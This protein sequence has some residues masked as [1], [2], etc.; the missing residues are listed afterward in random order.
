MRTMVPLAP[1][2]AAGATVDGS[3]ADR[4]HGATSEEQR[5]ETLVTDSGTARAVFDV[6]VA[7]ASEQGGG[8]NGQS[9]SGEAGSLRP[10]GGRPPSIASSPLLALGIKSFY[11]RSAIWD[12]K[13]WGR[14]VSSRK[15]LRRA[16]IEDP[17][18]GG[19]GG[20]HLFGSVVACKPHG[21]VCA[22]LQTIL[23]GAAQAH[24]NIA[25]YA[26]VRE[27]SR[28]QVS[29]YSE[30]YPGNGLR[31]VLRVLVPGA[32]DA[33]L[34]PTEYWAR[35]ARAAASM[36]SAAA[37][38]V[39][40]S[41]STEKEKKEESGGSVTVTA[42]DMAWVARGAPLTWDRVS[43]V[44][45]DVLF[46]LSGQH[47][48]MANGSSSGKWVHL[49]GDESALVSVAAHPHRR[50]LAPSF[51]VWFLYH[52]L[53]AIA[54]LNRCGIV[55]RCLRPEAFMFDACGELV[56][57]DWALYTATWNGVC[58]PFPIGDVAYLPPEV[59]EVEP[60][61]AKPVLRRVERMRTN[62]DGAV[63]GIASS[64][65]ISSS[66][67]GSGTSRR[68]VVDSHD[69]MLNSVDA[70]HPCTDVWS[71]GIVALQLL[72]LVDGEHN[73]SRYTI[74]KNCAFPIP[75]EKCEAPADIV[76]H[77]LDFCA[78]LI[79]GDPKDDESNV[80]GLPADGEFVSKEKATQWLI[81]SGGQHV[82]KSVEQWIQDV[83]KPY[84]ACVS[85]SASTG[86]GTQYI[87]RTLS[88]LVNVL[89]L[90]LEPDASRRPCASVLL[91]HPIFSSLC[92]Q[93]ADIER[94]GELEQQRPFMS[95]DS[96]HLRNRMGK[97]WYKNPRYFT[98]SF[99]WGSRRCLTTGLYGDGAVDV[100]EDSDDVCTCEACSGCGELVSPVVRRLLG[101]GDCSG[102]ESHRDFCGDCLYGF[103]FD[104]ICDITD[105]VDGTQHTPQVVADSKA[106]VN[107]QRKGA[108]MVPPWTYA[109]NSVFWELEVHRILAFARL[110]VVDV[111]PVMLY[112]T[113]LTDDRA[114]TEEIDPRRGQ[115]DQRIFSIPLSMGTYYGHDE[116]G[117]YRNGWGPT[118]AGP[119][120]S[121]RVHNSHS[122]GSLWEADGSDI[123]MRV[124][125]SLDRIMYR[126]C[127]MGIGPFLRPVTPV[128]VL[129][130]RQ[131]IFSA[132]E[133][134]LV[135][136]MLSEEKP[137]VFCSVRAISRGGLASPDS[138]LRRG[139]PFALALKLEEAEYEERGDVVEDWIL[140]GVEMVRV[141]GPASVEG[142]LWR[143]YAL[144]RLVFMAGSSVGARH[145]IRA[146]GRC[147]ACEIP[148]WLRGKVWATLLCPRGV[149]TRE[150][151]AEVVHRSLQTFDVATDSQMRVD[152][153]RCHQYLSLM[154]SLYG[155]EVVSVMVK[156]F[157]YSRTGCHMCPVE[158]EEPESDDT[159][160]LMGNHG[161]TSASAPN[162]PGARSGSGTP[163][164]IGRERTTTSSAG[165]WAGTFARARTHVYW[166][167][168]VSVATVFL[169]VF[170]SEPHIAYHCFSTFVNRVLANHFVDRSF[171]PLNERMW[172]FVH[173]LTYHD[174]EL[175]M[176][177]RDHDVTP[178][179]FGVPWF[180]TAFSHAFPAS[181]VVKI[182]DGIISWFGGDKEDEACLGLGDFDH[183]EKQQKK[184]VDVAQVRRGQMMR[185]AHTSGPVWYLLLFAVS[186][187]LQKRA[188]LLER[189]YNGILMYV[190]SVH[191]SVDTS[192]ER[193]VSMRENTPPSLCW[194]PRSMPL[195]ACAHPSCVA[196]NYFDVESRG[197]TVAM[198]PWEAAL[199][200]SYQSAIP[201]GL[202][203]VRDLAAH[204]CVLVD[205]RTSRDRQGSTLFGA[206]VA[207]PR[208]VASGM[209]RK[210]HHQRTGSS[211]SIGP[212]AA[213]SRR[214]S[215]K[216]V[217]KRQQQQQQQQQQQARENDGTE[218]GT[219]GGQG[220]TGT[221]VAGQAE[222]FMTPERL[223]RIDSLPCLNG[224]ALAAAVNGRISQYRTAC[225]DAGCEVSGVSCPV[226]IVGG[227]AGGV[228][229]FL[230]YE[231]LHARREGGDEGP[232]CK[233]ERHQYSTLQDYWGLLDSDI[234]SATHMKHWAG[235][236]EASLKP[237]SSSL[238]ESTDEN[239]G[240]IQVDP[241][242]AVAMSLL[243]RHIPGVCVLAGGISCILAEAP[244]ALQIGP[245]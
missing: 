28:N 153:T 146:L 241:A 226:V 141:L 12:E 134:R 203:H 21:L 50:C 59:L 127:L 2:P 147:S 240:S 84:R 132:T 71:L 236:H 1:A 19:E 3:D 34:S 115:Y 160:L 42:A 29:V 191:I 244:E 70:S 113:S 193:V 176:H 207:D 45:V 231:V 129:Q 96:R 15:G 130:F 211:G 72:M 32:G 98:R 37:Q 204:A 22:R 64:S 73:D 157:L 200:L 43:Y 55:H 104:M 36:G 174:P 81:T 183:E 196:G 206:I 77:V 58:V 178:D 65:S 230:E 213:L 105:V 195:M 120:Q 137:T 62:K 239:K 11:C 175:G 7:A 47:G 35:G 169:C 186:A 88:R 94:Q 142:Y 40:A 89:A 210:N 219:D 116:V 109:F 154:A 39:S 54:H 107:V 215:Q 102:T 222:L 172:T 78:D 164:T 171:E 228:A 151:M 100:F 119:G 180:L 197:D 20:E 69:V 235:E 97:Y 233:E 131:R 93:V 27:G 23:G 188:E 148:E 122:T 150:Q 66:R 221:G 52:A 177:F 165:A 111:D 216:A 24:R 57:A 125:E 74:E 13:R 179:L 106:I 225:A 229:A 5:G 194:T 184:A 26:R 143:C 199:P 112:S 53:A 118:A 152:I 86:G 117:S 217:A 234:S 67:R 170:P 243:R 224:D 76:V 91:A 56:L 16:C 30:H 145:L 167:G 232:K 185:A 121:H 103:S 126:G 181:I 182:Y 156:C 95:R 49:G 68:D 136:R 92:E 227:H 201:Y 124:M 108:R 189:D 10:L 8:R 187:V 198:Y 90:M 138:S 140:K 46:A 245:N 61:C 38:Q 238:H 149:I 60:E 114:T 220:S 205:V 17:M 4:Q 99:G 202:V 48:A 190:S 41:S 33:F 18:C 214:S 192:V 159:S 158:D 31:A 44:M 161:K 139:F 218:N 135:S 63:G 87:G 242:H 9:G 173:L 212:V 51:V 82:R 80:N 223:A 14:A 79:D 237:A 133:S 144:E 128:F 168:L 123:R 166:Q 208:S 110:N 83:T 25:R 6:L 163:F 162:S 85:A 155:H 101:L 209:R 75:M